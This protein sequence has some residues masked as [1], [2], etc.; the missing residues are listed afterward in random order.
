M[1]AILF[2]M[3]EAVLR[4]H[5][6]VRN[7]RHLVTMRNDCVSRRHCSIEV[8][9]VGDDL[10]GGLQH[11]RILLPEFPGAVIGIRA[12]FPVDLQCIAA[13]KRSPRRRCDDRDAAR[14][15]DVW[16]AR[17]RTLDR[18]HIEYAGHRSGR[19]V[20]KR[21]YPAIENRRTCDY[22]VAHAVD[23]RVEAKFRPTR[24]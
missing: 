24:H 17:L 16:L 15:D 5:G 2:D 12:R 1:A 8:T 18:E 14:K 6:L 23:L 21:T 3:R 11:R 19:R 22:C 4:F 20:V 13:L 10:A 9:V 7:E